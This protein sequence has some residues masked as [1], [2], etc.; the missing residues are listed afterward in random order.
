MTFLPTNDITF[1]GAFRKHHPLFRSM[2]VPHSRNP[3]TVRR[4]TRERTRSGFRRRLPVF[5]VALLPFGGGFAEAQIIPSPYRPIE[6]RQAASLFGGYLSLPTG[7]L[8]LGPRSGTFLGGRYAFETGGPIFLEGLLSYLPT[9]REVIDPRRQLGDRSI[10][11]TDVHLFMFDT[12]LSFSLTGRRTWNRLS[13]NLFVGA[14]LAYDAGRGNEL[15]D[16]LLPEDVFR[17]GVAFTANAG[18]AV[19]FVLGEKLMLMT[20]AGL[21]LWQLGTPTGFDDPTKRPDDE[22]DP[23]HIPEES[24]WVG[25]YGLTLSLAWRF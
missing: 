2:I 14:G 13:P 7:S 22:T 3:R 6:H 5:S 15:E 21:K 4:S 17:F 16:I 25:G 24:E 18:T 11:E 1:T 20:E 23:L 10:G 8:E 9:T 12:R 19:R